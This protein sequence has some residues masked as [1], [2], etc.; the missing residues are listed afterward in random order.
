MYHVIS[1]GLSILCLVLCIL[2]C[3]EAYRKKSFFQTTFGKFISKYH[4]ALAWLL[5]VLSLVHGIM[6]GKHPAMMSGKLTWIILIILI[7]TALP[8]K[9]LKNKTYL[10]IHRILSILFVVTLVLHIIHTFLV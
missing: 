10:K 7:I 3:L 8:K 5:L 4:A 6:K 1:Y 9:Y 2:C